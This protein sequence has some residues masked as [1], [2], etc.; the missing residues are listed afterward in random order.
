MR[1]KSLLIETKSNTEPSTFPTGC[2]NFILTAK[3]INGH[4]PSNFFTSNLL[5]YAWET[6]GQSWL[7]LVGLQPG[8]NHRRE[9]NHSTNTNVSFIKIPWL[10]PP[11]RTPKYIRLLLKILSFIET[12]KPMADTRTSSNIF[13]SEASH[14]E[15][16]IVTFLEWPGLHKT[17]VECAIKSEH[18]PSP[19]HTGRLGQISLSRKSLGIFQRWNSFCFFNYEVAAH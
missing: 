18:S 11:L 8:S 19:T 5:C 15:N 14:L 3:E 2:L 9:H 16:S 10:Y 17:C 7:W 6:S 12:L 4:M 13:W 1:E